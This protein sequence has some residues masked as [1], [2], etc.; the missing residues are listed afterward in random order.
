MR[1]LIMGCAVAALVASTA[2]SVA[3]PPV[4]FWA[5][6]SARSPLLPTKVGVAS[7]Y[8]E[9]FQGSLTASGEIYD[10]NGLT[11]A[12][13]DVPFGARLQ[14]TNLR[15][16]RSVVLRVNDRGPIV[17]GRVIDVSMAAAKQLRFLS[18][19]LAPVE[20]RVISLGGERE[21]KRGGVPTAPKP[22]AY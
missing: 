1:K 18:T 21:I 3:K 5:V 16:R 17:P 8:G 6:P 12:C 15:N 7:W 14:V 9:E 2:V 11:A 10:I 19:G 4:S 22:P 13:W 20:V